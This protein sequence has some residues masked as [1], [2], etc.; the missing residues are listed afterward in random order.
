L[1]LLLREKLLQKKGNGTTRR[2]REISVG[3]R[4]Q[5]STTTSRRF[6]SLPHR[7]IHID[8]FEG[9]FELRSLRFTKQRRSVE[10]CGEERVAAKE[11]RLTPAL[12]LG[13]HDGEIGVGT[14]LSN[15]KVGEEK[16]KPR[17]GSANASGR[18]KRKEVDGRKQKSISHS[19]DSCKSHHTHNPPSTQRLRA[20]QTSTA[21]PH[22][23]RILLPRLGGT[24]SA[25]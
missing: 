1:R 11:T 19:L 17:N 2:K 5:A 8:P 20:L 9:M 13:L 25:P 10:S 21:H 22:H 23:T 15:L 4:L 24:L 6:D 12:L 18:V 7:S 3:L 14:T 16:D